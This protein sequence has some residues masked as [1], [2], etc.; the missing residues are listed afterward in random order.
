MADGSY[1][2]LGSAS[3]SSSSFS[4]SAPRPGGGP[5]VLRR[6]PRRGDGGDRVRRSPRRPHRARRPGRHAA[7]TSSPTAPRP[8]APPA[9]RPA[10]AST[11]AGSAS[12]SSRCAPATTCGARWA[13]GSSAA[14]PRVV[15][16]APSDDTLGTRVTPFQPGLA[17][18]S[19]GTP[20]VDAMI[21]PSGARRGSPS[22]PAPSCRISI[23]TT[24]WRSA[25]L[26]S[27]RGAASTRSAGTTRT[28]TGAAYDLVVLRSTWDYARRR[29]EF[30]AWASA[31]AA[32]GQPGRHRRVEHR[33]A[34]P[35]R[36]RPGRR[37]DRADRS[38]SGRP[39]RG[40]CRPTG[41]WV[42]K[43]AVS[44]GSLDTGRYDARDPDHRQLAAAHVARLQAAGRLVMVQPY[45]PAIDA[46]GETAL[47]F[48]GGAYSHADPQGC[49]C[50]TAPTSAWTGLY[51]PEEITAREPTRGRARGG[52][53]GAGRGA[54]AAPAGCS[55]P[56]STS[57][58]APTAS[59]CWSSW[60]SPSRP[61]SWARPP[62]PPPASPPP[63]LAAARPPD[64]APGPRRRT[65][66]SVARGGSGV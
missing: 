53:A 34:V 28:S 20:R 7:P 37:A 36:A 63:I 9:R 52:R 35:A 32:A 61:C 51:K 54:A 41:E 66:P 44:A 56:G 30:V 26:A 3:A 43:P 1:T 10:S 12:W 39:T 19:T 46:D 58:P 13:G 22:R 59:R 40:G 11:T 57:S 14:E 47:L 25:P 18:G 29:D 50:S 38:G 16:P 23:P 64:A 48:L 6:R 45:L 21:D 5:A 42:I 31:G 4:G 49:R 2:T 15:G 24:G 65:G 8:P 27:T 60:S 62:A 55:T 33:Q 17:A